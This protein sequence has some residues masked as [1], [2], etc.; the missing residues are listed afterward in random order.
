MGKYSVFSLFLKDKSLMGLV[1][2]TQKKQRV[3]GCLIKYL[4]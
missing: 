1:L 2:L 3:G 4:I